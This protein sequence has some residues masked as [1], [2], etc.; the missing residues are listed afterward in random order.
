[1]KKHMIA[2]ILTLALT[3]FAVADTGATKPNKAPVKVAVDVDALKLELSEA[4]KENEILKKKIVFLKKV[5]DYL[6]NEIKTE[7]AP[8]R[9]RGR[10]TKEQY[11][12]SRG[13]I[14]LN[15]SRPDARPT[16]RK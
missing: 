13:R 2:G 11:L 15:P 6:V 7:A 12:K 5:N 8:A 1:M 16:G 3:G 10:M 9:G 4:K 14:P